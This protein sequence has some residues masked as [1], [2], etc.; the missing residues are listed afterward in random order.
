MEKQSQRQQQHQN[1]YYFPDGSET[2]RCLIDG[3]HGIY[4]PQIFAR[5]FPTTD[6]GITEEQ[7][8][9]LLEGPNPAGAGD[10]YWDVWDEVLTNAE[11]RDGEGN[12]WYLMQD[13]DLFAAM[14]FEPEE[15]E[16]EDESENKN[17]EEGK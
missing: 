10:L 8:E 14:S 5:N 2:M 7:T 15:D 4:I 3:H 17:S 13:G 9:I 1:V 16:D 12:V 6:W 11:W